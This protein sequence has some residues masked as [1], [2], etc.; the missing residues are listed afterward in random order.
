MA[1]DQEYNGWTNWDTWNANLWLANDEGTY[2]QL[3]D[4]A[5]DM[6][7]EEFGAE[8]RELL[9][10]LGNPDGIEYDNVDW[11]EVRQAFAEE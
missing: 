4:R 8:A 7:A 10:G 9:D 1:Q 11:E 2:R 6:T 5:A 3:C